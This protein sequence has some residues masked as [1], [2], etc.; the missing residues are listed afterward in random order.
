MLSEHTD[1]DGGGGSD[2]GT[3]GVRVIP[4]S[5][6]DVEVAASTTPFLLASIGRE[7]VGLWGGGLSS[8]F[9]GA[10]SVVDR[11]GDEGLKSIG[12]GESCIAF[13]AL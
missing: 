5:S 12:G 7:R 1:E 2:G 11:E 3:D 4:P 10:T 13:Y 8:T 6:G 9:G